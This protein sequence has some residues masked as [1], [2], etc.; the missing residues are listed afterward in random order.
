MEEKMRKLSRII[1]TILIGIMF[2]SLSTA[3]VSA[4][5]WEFNSEG[6]QK[7]PFTPRGYLVETERGQHWLSSVYD[8]SGVVI[9]YTGVRNGIEYLDAKKSDGSD[10]TFYAMTD[11]KPW[12]DK[13]S[14]IG[15]GQKYLFA[16]KNGSRIANF[17]DYVKTPPTRGDKVDPSG[18]NKSWVFE[19]E[20]FTL[21][22]GC[23]YEFGFLRG[24][25]AN[26]GITLVLAEDEKGNTTGYIQ[27]MSEG[28]TAEE[29]SRYNS[30]KDKEYEFISSWYKKEGG[31][32]T[33]NFVPMRFSVQ[34]YADLSKWESAVAEAQ[35]FLDSVTE[36]ELKQGKYVRSN[37]EQ[38]ELLL[39]AL[40]EKAENEVKMQLQTEANA[41]IRSMKNELAAMLE[42]AMS[43]KPEPADM[44]KLKET[45]REAEALY[46]KANVNVGLSV[47]QYG[48]IEV[49]NLQDEIGEAHKVDRFYPQSEIDAQVQALED[50]MEEVLASKV[51]EE[52]MIFYDKITDIYVVAP[53][54]SLSEDAKLFVRIMGKETEDYK[55]IEKNL[56]EKDT[57]A[58][59]YRI[60]FYEDDQKIQPNQQVEVQMP[61]SDNISQK[62]S[63]VYSVG[64]KGSLTEVASVK[65]NGT[66]FFKTE[67]LTAFVMAGSTASDAEKAAARGERV[68]KM[69]AQKQDKKADD[70]QTKLAKAKKKKEEFKDPLNKIL[71]RNANTA[72]FSNDVRKKTDPQILILAAIVLAAVALAVGVRAVTEMRRN[73]KRR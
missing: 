64:K 14:W 33:V 56:S 40:N 61:I 51:M 62:T 34:T 20:G 53:V 72:T 41:S 12:T 39:K 25:Q 58:V 50:A 52:Q 47:G 26:N 21:E 65:S 38:L 37:I 57:E 17:N 49:D 10:Y 45:I 23:R 28:L 31:G 54:G 2:W 46:A 71:K 7:N 63:T 43:E 68:R 1:G 13:S 24:M 42:K 8:N 3:F 48:Q 36:K 30:E 5:V 70:K 29:R 35:D 67:K 73:R 18:E 9:R 59:F 16:Y 69:M 11:R 66:Q 6:K 15:Y 44:S 22:P 27:Q 55:S 60:Q 4:D 19:I 32:Y